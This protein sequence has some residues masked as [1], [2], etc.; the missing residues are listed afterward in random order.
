MVVDTGGSESE[1]LSC[2][3]MPC[4]RC[5]LGIRIRESKPT[6]RLTAPC[7]FVVWFPIMDYYIYYFFPLHTAIKP[8]G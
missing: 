8:A 7:F 5:K 4:R 6:L 2:S 1:Y 3:L